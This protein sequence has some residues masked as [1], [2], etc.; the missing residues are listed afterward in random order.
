MSLEWMKIG[1]KR[2]PV[3]TYKV[4]CLGFISYSPL[5]PSPISH[6]LTPSSCH[7]HRQFTPL[8]PPHTHTHV[9][10]VTSRC[11]MVEE[12]LLS[13]LWRSEVPDKGAV[14]GVSWHRLMLFDCVTLPPAC[15]LTAFFPCF[16]M[17]APPASACSALVL[18]TSV[19]GCGGT[20]L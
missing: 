13:Q 4:F 7:T 2:E 8:A 14:P 15:L 3:M 11:L 17:G 10:T 18:R 16:F 6:T 12:F 1:E 19:T 9:R 5:T 20:C